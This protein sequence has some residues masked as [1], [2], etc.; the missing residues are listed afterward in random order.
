MYQALYRKY[1]PRRFD[2]VTGQEHIT[3]TLR[4]QL[5]TDRLSHAYLFVG[6]RGTGKT[7]CAKILSRAM[8]CLFPEDGEPCNKC[9]SCV[10][11]ESGS[12]LDVLEIDA[13]SNNG[14]ENVR[15]LREE[16]IYSPAS[17]SKRIYII[18]EVHMLSNAAFNALLKILE[19]PPEHLIFILAT[20]ERH[21]V[22][23]TILSRCQ[24]FSFKR[25]SP[26]TIAARLGAVAEK[27]GLTLSADAAE[28]L[29]S[30]ADGS[31]RDGLSLLDQCASDSNIDLQRVLDTIGLTGQAPLAQLAEAAARRDAS[32]ALSILDGL[33]NDG[34]DMSS[35]LSELAS[36]MRDVLVFQLSPDSPLLSGIFERTEL[37]KLSEMLAPERLFAFLN[38]IREAGLGLSR[39]G[40]AKLSADMCVFRL[41]DERLSDD[42]ASLLARV[43]R[44]ENSGLVR[45]GGQESGGAASPPPAVQKNAAPEGVEEPGDKKSAPKTP[46]NPE[47]KAPNSKLKPEPQA[48]R[49]GAFWQD[50]LEQ[51]KGDVS[52]HALLSD[53]SEISVELQA[54]V[55]LIRTKTPF[56]MAQIESKMFSDPL[57]TAAAKVLGHEVILRTALPEGGIEESK[58]DKLEKLIN[59]FDIASYE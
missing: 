58:H 40:S 5:A 33:Y 17:V 30:L 22:P 20:T 36:L 39:G 41:C 51:L 53:S 47:P 37:S 23:A 3:V 32:A 2:D 7:T 44:I 52:V 1:R 38:V 42:N 11:I 45:P 12:I 46:A 50:I 14:V 4:R 57:R 8:N 31:M 48:Q 21:K 43:E 56:S 27:E 26:S 18:D 34:R 6:T 16:A 59:T 49:D 24:R 13:A 54:N 9:A 35:L 15:A 25:L 28:K 29:A 19:E 55:L 10:G